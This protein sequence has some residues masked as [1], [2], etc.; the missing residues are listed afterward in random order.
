MATAARKARSSRN[1]DVNSGASGA[2]K[3]IG[4]G[5]VALGDA[6][7]DSSSDIELSPTTARV[8]SGGDSSSDIELSD[9]DDWAASPIN[10]VRSTKPAAN[11]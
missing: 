8:R 4:N 5:S 10:A 2:A 7:G 3:A 9:N 11:I 1:T 6:A